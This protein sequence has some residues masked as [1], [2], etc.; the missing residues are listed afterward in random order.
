MYKRK[1][2]APF[3]SSHTHTSEEVASPADSTHADLGRSGDLGCHSH[4]MKSHDWGPFGSVAGIDNGGLVLH[5]GFV[6]GQYCSR[7]L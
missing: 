7:H 2:L 6:G 3:S 5:N 1:S 4:E